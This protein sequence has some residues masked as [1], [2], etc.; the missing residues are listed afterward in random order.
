M[1]NRKIFWALFLVVFL[2]AGGFMLHSAEAASVRVEFLNVQEG[3]TI[4]LA[5]GQTIT[6]QV[7]V[8]ADEEF[9]Y[10]L[11]LSDEQF[12]GKGIKLNG[13]DIETRTG[14]AILSLTATGKGSTANL[15]GGVAPVGLVVGVRYPGGV[16]YAERVDFY[17]R[18]P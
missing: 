11:M 13:S 17:V 10:A 14:Y 7:E 3:Q 6:F 18:V 16:V 4:D 5:V 15:P 9:T 12:P 1:R 2:F 8:R